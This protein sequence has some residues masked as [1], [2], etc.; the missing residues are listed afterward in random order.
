F[1][2][3][4]TNQTTAIHTTSL[5]AALPIYACG[6]SNTCTQTITVND[7]TPPSISC[8]ATAGVSCA[9]SVPDHVNNYADFVTAGGSASDLCGGNPTI[10]WVSDDIS[11]QTCA[12][13]YTITRTYMATDACGN[14]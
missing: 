6:N 10:A 12:N 13:R 5:H 3:D 14:T 1:I 9:T 4:I 7:V 11:N 8:P 2:D